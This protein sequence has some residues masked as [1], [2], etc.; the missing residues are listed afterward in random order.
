MKIKR[1]G[2][3]VWHGGF[4]GGSGNISTDSGALR[5]Y[6]YGV[7]SRF[8]GQHGSNPEELIAAAHASCFAMALALVLGEAH[9]VPAQ[10]FVAAEVTLEQQF[11][12][13]AITAV[14]LSVRA[15][16]PGMQAAAF[17]Q[18]AQLAKQKCPVSKLLRAQVSLQAALTSAAAA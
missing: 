13:F 7:A 14:D 10:L 2:S 1:S 17:E 4:P 6:P 18:C 5:S 8:E 9:V 11:G 15:D 12:D 16:V 3:V